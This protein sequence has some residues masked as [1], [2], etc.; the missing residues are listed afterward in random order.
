MPSG[1][2]KSRFVDLGSGK[3]L[4][5]HPPHTHDLP[6][7]AI[8]TATLH[9]EA[10]VARLVIRDVVAW[11]NGTVALGGSFVLGEE[12][13]GAGRAVVGS[14]GAAGGEFCADGALGARVQ[15][16][17]RAPGDVTSE[18][19]AAVEAFAPQ[20]AAELVRKCHTAIYRCTCSEPFQ[21]DGEGDGEPVI[22]V[23]ICG[24]AFFLNQI[25]RM[26][27]AAVAVAAG[28]G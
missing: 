13:F 12:S 11:G 2:L 25:R 19:E 22:S 23:W 8:N 28:S 27:G 14:H 18:V 15:L 1:G 20:R 10:V 4:P 16:A 7:E 17:R 26:V 6:R 5:H 9:A 24:Q 3:Y 21:S